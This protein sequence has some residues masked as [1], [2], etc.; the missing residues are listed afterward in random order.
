MKSTNWKTGL[1]K[2]KAFVINFFFH[3]TNM[4][5]IVLS[6]TPRVF[7]SACLFVGNYAPECTLYCIVSAASPAHL[8][9][10]EREKCYRYKSLS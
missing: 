6:P 3:V 4:K 7:L 5:E 8:P 10:G 2:S 9:T 1:Y